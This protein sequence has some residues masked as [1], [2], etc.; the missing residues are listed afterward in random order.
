MFFGNF[1]LCVV[2]S[3]IYNLQLTFD[4]SLSG[5]SII[6]EA[7]GTSA[8]ASFPTA[9]LVFSGAGFNEDSST[10]AAPEDITDILRA[11]VCA[12]ISAV[13]T[14]DGFESLVFLP[15]AT[16]A[17]GLLSNDSTG[18][19]DVLTTKSSGALS[20]SKNCAA[21]QEQRSTSLANNVGFICILR[22]CLGSLFPLRLS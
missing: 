6:R 1:I 13:L 7:L 8:V 4:S 21:Y 19:S 15:R 3:C 5:V 2:K 14:A 20:S 12:S 10:A 17:D 18:T 9:T 11:G 16:A 22:L